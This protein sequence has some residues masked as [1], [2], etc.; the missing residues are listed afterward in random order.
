MSSTDEKANLLT[1][2]I[3]E[4]AP[5]TPSIDVLETLM[6]EVHIFKLPITSLAMCTFISYQS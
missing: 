6:K 3:L 5:N 4:E 2:R 1:V